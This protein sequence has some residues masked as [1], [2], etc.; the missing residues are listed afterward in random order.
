MIFSE[1]SN[2][3]ESK[4]LILNNQSEKNDLTVMVKSMHKHL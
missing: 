3:G 1:M 2:S 4:E